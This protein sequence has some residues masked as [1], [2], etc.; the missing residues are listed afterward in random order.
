MTG[1]RFTAD[2][3]YTKKNH[4][5]RISSPQDNRFRALVGFFWQEQYHD[6]E[7]HWLVE[8]GV[9]DPVRMNAG[10]DPRFFDTVYLNSLERWDTDQAVFG[11]LAYDI[12]DDLELTVGA[13]FFRPEVDVVGFFGFGAGYAGIWSSTGETQ[14]DR[15]EGEDGW[16]PNFDGQNDWKDKP[17]LNVDKGISESDHVGRV[18]LSWS[19]SD[20]SMVYATWSEG[21]RPGGINRRPTAGSYIS[22]FLTNYEAG[23]KTQWMDNSFQFNGAIFYSTWDDFQVSFTG[24]NAITQVDNGPSAKVTGF[25]GQF[26]WLPSDNLRLT[27][28]FAFIDSE[29][30]DDYVNLDAAGNVTKVLAPKGT[31]LPVTAEFKGNIAARYHFDIGS[32]ESYVQG[33]LSYEGERGSDMDQSANDIRGNVP[34][35]T[36]LDLSAGIGRDSW[37]VDLFIKNATNEDAPLYYTSQCTAETCG[38]QNY[39]VRVRPTTIGLKFS[40]RF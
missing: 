36:I 23:W 17:C 1:A 11:T 13:R 22:D 37:A 6:F 38:S 34:A 29:L 26:L 18:N 25:E 2:D 24:A 15:V 7:Q 39:G 40:Q 21:Y 16:T 10:T 31:P 33:V 9:N 5:I 28:A 14:C 27:A 19:V 3:G 32:F 12:T 20:D 35:Y 8:G 4:E 30:L